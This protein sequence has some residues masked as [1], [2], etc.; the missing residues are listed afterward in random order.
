M[1]EGRQLQVLAR[2]ASIG[3][4]LGG[5]GAGLAADALTGRLASNQLARARQLRRALVWLGPAFIKVGQALSTR[6]DLAPKA[7]LDE[8]AILQDA[9][10]GFA[11]E[12]AFT[13]IEE[14]LGAPLASLFRCISP[15]PIAAASL[16]QV[17]KAE[18]LD[19]RAVRGTPK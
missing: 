15:R 18:L 13:T 1:F 10:P 7:Y 19:G 4:S 17:Y 8:L 12:E 3:L 14:Q 9:L 6:P 16:G 11:D 2:L 5:W